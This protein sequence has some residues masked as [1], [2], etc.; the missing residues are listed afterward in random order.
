VV[1]IYNDVVAGYNC[2]I[3]SN[4]DVV[5]GYNPIVFGYNLIIAE[6]NLIVFR[7]GRKFLEENM[8]GWDGNLSGGNF[9]WAEAGKIFVA[10]LV[11]IN[12]CL[13]L[14]AYKTLKSIAAPNDWK[15]HQ[16]FIK[17]PRHRY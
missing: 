16:S 3:A 8:G 15:T 7:D 17:I 6:Y 4:N 9:F 14:P 13:L 1:A 11:I 10:Y 12:I 5:A 2:V